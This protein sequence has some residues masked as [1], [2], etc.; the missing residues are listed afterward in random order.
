MTFKSY[1]SSLYIKNVMTKKKGC[2]I[3]LKCVNVANGI[4]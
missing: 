2:V 1:M 3:N 4:P